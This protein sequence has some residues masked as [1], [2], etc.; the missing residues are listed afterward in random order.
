MVTEILSILEKFN[1]KPLLLVFLSISL[2]SLKP[3]HIL[4]SQTLENWVILIFSIILSYLILMGWSTFIKWLNKR[5]YSEDISDIGPFFGVIF[6]TI[7]VVI[8]LTFLGNISE[9]LTFQILRE[10]GFIWT[11]SLL[12][13]ALESMK[14]S[15]FRNQKI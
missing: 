3:E 14:L 1:S 7:F 8:V 15:R 12:L 9:P 6:L 11:A 10:E 5:L 2:S 4:M 13:F